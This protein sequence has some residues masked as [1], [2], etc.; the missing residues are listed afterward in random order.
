MT[1]PNRRGGDPDTYRYSFQGQEKDDAIKGEG[2][3]TNFKY[4]MHDPRVGRFFATDPLEK[5]YPWYTPY[6]FSGNKVIA[7]MELEGLEETPSRSN[8]TRTN[9]DSGA[10]QPP[11]L[12]Q[13][14]MND[15]KGAA[16]SFWNGVTS[17]WE[18]GT[19]LSMF[20]GREQLMEENLGKGSEIN[21]LSRFSGF[22]TVTGEVGLDVT[23]N[24]AT[25][26]KNGL[27]LSMDSWYESVT[28]NN[29]YRV[30]YGT[31]QATNLAAGFLTPSGEVSLFSRI[32]GLA[33]LSTWRAY[34]FQG[35]KI[36]QV[37][38]GYSRLHRGISLRIGRAGREIGFDFHRFN[39]VNKRPVFHG[40]YFQDSFL[41]SQPIFSKAR[42]LNWIKVANEV[43][44]KNVFKL[45]KNG[46]PEAN[47]TRSPVFKSMQ[48][49]SHKSAKKF[50]EQQ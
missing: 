10:K 6:Q 8:S 49:N 33:R 30:A 50:L 38:L 14:L 1:L 40:H 12:F 16:Q 26:L 11:S 32:S 46:F 19:T 29:I 35:I 39:G 27:S 7:F 42:H 22:D 15:P 44:W 24:V 3:S 4:R 28:S 41:N 20:Q 21:T 18:Q 31:G 34:G 2:N 37:S 45:M 17:L 25:E 23:L 43:G 47:F 5:K 13:Q 48:K 36:G 9:R